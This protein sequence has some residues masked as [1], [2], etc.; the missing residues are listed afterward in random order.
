MHEDQGRTRTCQWP[1]CN[2]VATR[3]YPL[4]RSPA[5]QTPTT[6]LPLSAVLG[7]A[8][9]HFREA[10]AFHATCRQPRTAWGSRSL[11]MPHPVC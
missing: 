1:Y 4:S 11:A 5:A 6:T 8:A 9:I 10:S 2:T 3:H 7:A